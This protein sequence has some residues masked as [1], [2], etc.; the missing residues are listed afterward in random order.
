MEKRAF[1][2]IRVGYYPRMS[3]LTSPFPIP[4]TSSRKHEL[5]NQNR[6]YD[7]CPSTT[8]SLLGAD[9]YFASLFTD[10]DW[11]FCDPYLKA[12]NCTTELGFSS[13]ASNAT[14]FYSPEEFPTNG[15]L[16]LFDTRGEGEIRTPVS[17]NVF[18]WTVNGVA[19]TV[20]AAIVTGTETSGNRESTSGGAA[21][22]TDTRSASTPSETGAASVIGVGIWKLCCVLAA[23]TMVSMLGL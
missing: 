22:E 2:A 4:H 8:P 3:S 7:I 17:G 20:S 16:S 6:I 21:V 1:A 5:T 19:R 23:G 15:S 10:T 13:P 18:T 11:E 9:T 12:Y 14:N